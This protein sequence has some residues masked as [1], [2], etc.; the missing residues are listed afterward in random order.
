MARKESKTEKGH[1]E[2]KFTGLFIP[3]GILAMGNLSTI[4]KLVICD[5]EYFDRNRRDYRFSNESLAVKF[6]VGRRTVQKAI[7]RLKSPKFGFVVDDA[8]SGS[9][10]Y[11]RRLKLSD[12]GA[13]LFS[14]EGAK[15][16][17]YGAEEGAECAPYG[18]K[19]APYGAKEGAESALETT[20][21]EEKQLDIKRR[22]LCPPAGFIKPTT[23]QV[24]AYA[25]SIGFNL[26]GRVF[27][28]FY[29]SKGWSVGKSRMC[30]WK[31][32][33]RTW[34]KRK[35]KNNGEGRTYR[36]DIEYRAAERAPG[37][38]EI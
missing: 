37:A 10:R 27:C 24:T 16:A 34:K 36:R 1:N 23:E 14:A 18:A 31:A 26:D 11:L 28:D 38:M 20:K 33:V 12:T 3:A 22:G 13:A 8:Q 35:G 6:G 9:G 5:V 15:S 19:C 32:A 17:P 7:G 21:R 2:S 29:D 25:K 30:D 4:E